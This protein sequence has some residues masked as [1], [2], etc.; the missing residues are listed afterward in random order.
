M[1]ALRARRKYSKVDHLM[2]WVADR[3]PTRQWVTGR[4]ATLCGSERNPHGRW[5]WVTWIGGDG[6]YVD[7]DPPR[8]VRPLCS[9]CGRMLEDLAILAD[10]R[11]GTFPGEDDPKGMTNSV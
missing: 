4:Y 5:D 3:V 7:L 10:L 11:P 6:L 2:V 8:E 1:S 9:R